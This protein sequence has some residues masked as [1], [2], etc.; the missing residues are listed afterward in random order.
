MHVRQPDPSAAASSGI[1]GIQRVQVFICSL[2]KDEAELS[3]ARAAYFSAN[4]FHATSA[5]V[6]PRRARPPALGQ[7]VADVLEQ[8]VDR[9]RVLRAA[10]HLPPVLK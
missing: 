2:F 6:G 3:K 8:D 5:A 7:L 9:G 4:H 10:R 1:V